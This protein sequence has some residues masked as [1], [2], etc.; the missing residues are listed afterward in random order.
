MAP[1][2]HRTIG[3]RRTDSRVMSLR[4]GRDILTP[5]NQVVE[6]RN[7]SHVG[8]RQDVWL[9]FSR[10]SGLDQSPM[11][12][13]VVEAVRRIP[14]GRPTKR[15]AEGVLE[16]WRGTCSTKHELLVLLTRNR[17][18]GLNPRIM[19]RV[20]TLTPG[21][22]R[23]LFGEAGSAVVPSQGVADVHTYMT[24]VVE[25]RRV[26]IDATV[27]GAPWNGRSDMVLACGEG[28]DFDGGDDPRMTKDRLVQEHCDANAR[29][30]VIE[31]LA[32]LSGA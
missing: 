30:R 21:V 24:A 29:D 1:Q 13:D 7:L 10:K 19:H 28:I 16:E 18:P 23:R 15:T 6:G 8:G 12:R 26:V 3:N 32:R 25:G 9:D 20:Y 5:A 11:F 22:A 17:W 31:A 2:D 14:Y 27:P 4:D